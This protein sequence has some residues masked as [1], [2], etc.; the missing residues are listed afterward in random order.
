M[1]SINNKEAQKISFKANELHRSQNNDEAIKLCDGEL[2]KYLGSTLTICIEAYIYDMS[3]NPSLAK[4]NY[5]SAYWKKDESV[6]ISKDTDRSLTLSAGLLAN[7]LVDT[8]IE[9]KKRLIWH[10][11]K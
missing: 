4:T 7:D 3:G 11:T 1:Q 5:N 6:D 10:S 2:N 8:R 9:F